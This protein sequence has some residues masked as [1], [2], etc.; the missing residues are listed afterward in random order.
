MLYYLDELLTAMN[1]TPGRRWF[2]IASAV[3]IV[4]IFGAFARAGVSSWVI[5]P[6]VCIE[7]VCHGALVASWARKDAFE[8]YKQGERACEP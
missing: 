7:F 8:A 6:A 2:N 1:A 5:V 4:V 3:L